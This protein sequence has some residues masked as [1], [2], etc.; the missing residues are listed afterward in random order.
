[1]N[2][3]KYEAKPWLSPGSAPALKLRRGFS[4]IEIAAVIGIIV[5]VSVVAF[6]NLQGRRNTVDLNNTTQ[7][8][9]SLLREAQSKSVSQTSGQVWGVHFENAATPFYSI[10]SGSTYSASAETGHY[11]L[12]NNVCYSNISSGS[13]QDVT[14]ASISGQP[15]GGAATVQLQLTPGCSTALGGSGGGGGSGEGAAGTIGSWSTTT[16]LPVSVYY[17]AA[18]ANGGYMYVMGGVSS[19]PTTT[20]RYAPI[21]TNGTLGSWTNTTALPSTRYAHPSIVN[22]GYVYVAGGYVTGAGNSYTSTVL[23]APINGNGTIGSWS[24]TTAFPNNLND[25]HAAMN[26][27]YIYL[28]GGLADGAANTS[29]VYYAPVNANGTIGSWSTTTVLP[30]ALRMQSILFNNGYIYTLAGNTT[31]GATSTVLYASINANGTIGSWSRTTALPSALY[32]VD[33]AGIVSGGYIYVIGGRNLM[34]SG[35]STVLYAPINANGTIGSWSTT[36]ALP[37]LLY[38]EPVVLNN[39][40]VYALGGWV[41]LPSG[42]TST[43]VYAQLSSSGPIIATSTVTVSAQGQITF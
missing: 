23:Y 9:A 43:V 27:G 5:I 8:I 35:T 31:G 34:G 16:A 37:N 38:Q 24:K 1:M 20:V 11:R 42:A 4:L 15:S 3:S 12:P 6:V 36:T 41:G 33:A 29:T 26:N 39:G 28:I 30:F 18:V 2:K 19:A 14:F 7:Q 40:Y 22:D 32:D 13:S 10:F 25:W 21:N 17:D